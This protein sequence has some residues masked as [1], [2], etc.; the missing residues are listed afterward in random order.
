MLLGLAYAP[1]HAAFNTIGVKLRETLVPDSPD[2]DNLDGIQ[3]WAKASNELGD[4]LQ[5]TMYD[6]KT[7]GP[8]FPSLRHFCSVCSPV[9]SNGELSLFKLLLQ[10]FIHQFRLGLPF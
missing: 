2:Q 4:L 10:Y 3:K 5:I 7:L 6:W 9:C 8:D 1:V